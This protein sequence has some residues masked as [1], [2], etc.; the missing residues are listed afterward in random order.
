MRDGEAGGAGKPCGAGQCSAK[1]GEAWH[2]CGTCGNGVRGG[3]S[4]VFCRVRTASRAPSRRTDE[5]GKCF[6]TIRAESDATGEFATA[7]RLH[8]KRRKTRGFWLAEIDNAE[9]TTEL[10]HLSDSQKRNAEAAIQKARMM[11]LKIDSATERLAELD[12][13]RS[14]LNGK[15]A[16]VQQAARDWKNFRID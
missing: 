8:P 2:G 13:Q 10:E 3:S 7:A 1:A 4:G 15:L 16:A 9:L 14:E 5:R 11:I 6:K 12:E